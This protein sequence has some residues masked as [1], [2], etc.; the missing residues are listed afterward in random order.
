MYKMLPADLLVFKKIKEKQVKQN[1][2]EAFL[3]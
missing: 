1:Q 2:E 3:K